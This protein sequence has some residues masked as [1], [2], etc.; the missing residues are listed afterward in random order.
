V[1]TN[2]LRTGDRCISFLIDTNGDGESFVYQNGIWTRNDE[3][4]APCSTGGTSHSKINSTLTLPQPLQNPITLLKGSG[5]QEES[6]SSCA[7]TSFEQ[8]LTRTGD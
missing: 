8:T 5:Y 7:S 4:D 2:C 6:G 1:K 3:Y